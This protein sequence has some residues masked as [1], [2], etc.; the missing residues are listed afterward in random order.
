MSNSWA[1]NYV[2][3]EHNR[4][5]PGVYITPK[6]GNFKSIIGIGLASWYEILSSH[7]IPDGKSTGITNRIQKDIMQQKSTCNEY[8]TK[9]F[10]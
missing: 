4:Q 6:H 1:S 7:F 3:M 5:N 9:S 2:Y 8:Y 10:D